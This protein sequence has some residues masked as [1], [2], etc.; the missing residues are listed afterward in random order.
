VDGGAGSLVVRSGAGGGGELL[1]VVAAGAGGEVVL[2]DGA[3][4][5]VLA[6]GDAAEV[7]RRLG[8]LAAGGSSR[9]PAVSGSEARPMR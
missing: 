9:V 2:V 6:G 5:D 3:G 8:V 7:V 1:D 4:G